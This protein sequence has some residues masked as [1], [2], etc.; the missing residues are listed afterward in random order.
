MEL[1]IGADID[2]VGGCHGLK[3]L[4]FSTLTPGDNSATVLSWILI[5][6][7]VDESLK[8]DVQDHCYSQ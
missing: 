5:M 1:T 8:L 4:R 7:G 3:A 6:K 2:I